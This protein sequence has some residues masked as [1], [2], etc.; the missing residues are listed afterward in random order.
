MR[1]DGNEFG[2]DTTIRITATS[3]EASKYIEI[4]MVPS[5]IIP[6]DINKTNAS[7][8][9]IVDDDSDPTAIMHP[10]PAFFDYINNNGCNELKID[11]LNIGASAFENCPMMNRSSAPIHSIVIDNKSASPTAIGGSAFSGCASIVS[12]SLIGTNKELLLGDNA[13]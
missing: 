3:G 8:Y 4:I 13:F 9:F 7:T 2:E 12:I 6:I 10:K 5:A 11:G 1:Y